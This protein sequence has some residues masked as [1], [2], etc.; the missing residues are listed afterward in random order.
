[1]IHEPASQTSR[2][3]VSYAR[4]IV[5]PKTLNTGMFPELML[6]PSDQIVAAAGETDTPDDGSVE[7][8]G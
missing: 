2:M 3:A 8:L 7:S 4:G 1:M 6:P 5:L